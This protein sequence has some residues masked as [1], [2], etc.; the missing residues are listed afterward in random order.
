LLFWFRL[1]TLWSCPVVEAQ[2]RLGF[3]P[4]FA[5]GEEEFL[6]WRGF[7]MLEPWGQHRA[8]HVAAYAT[9]ILAGRAGS[10]VEVEDCLPFTP[11][12]AL[13]HS[14]EPGPCLADIRPAIT[15]MA[16]EASGGKA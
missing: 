3:E 13:E 12:E 8:E 1:A 15:Q 5:S 2:I 7:Y 9:S 16:V 10:P 6:W 14:R 4:S 11:L